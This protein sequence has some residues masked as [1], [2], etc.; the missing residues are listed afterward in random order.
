MKLTVS[1]KHEPASIGVTYRLYTAGIRL[2][3]TIKMD[4][5]KG[6]RVVLLVSDCKCTLG[7]VRHTMNYQTRAQYRPLHP[8]SMSVLVVSDCMCMLDEVDLRCFYT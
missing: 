7:M 2:L 6:R 5:C 4:T 8:S 3:L 1:D